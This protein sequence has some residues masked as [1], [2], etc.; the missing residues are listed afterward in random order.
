MQAAVSAKHGEVRGDRTI[1]SLHPSPWE[2]SGMLSSKRRWRFDPFN[3]EG[4]WW[5][6]EEMHLKFIFVLFERQSYK[7]L[8]DLFIQMYKAKRKKD[9]FLSKKEERFWLILHLYKYQA[10]FSGKRMVWHLWTK[11]NG[12]SLLV[13]SVLPQWKTTAWHS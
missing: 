8:P 4:N 7:F 5:S 13:L 9:F 2:T 6:H 12:H 11:N 3:W 10:H 1:P